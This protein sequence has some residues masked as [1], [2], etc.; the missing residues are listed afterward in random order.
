MP[1]WRMQFYLC[2]A[3]L[4]QKARLYKVKK[5]AVSI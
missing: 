2:L 4:K 5:D 3:R 1:K